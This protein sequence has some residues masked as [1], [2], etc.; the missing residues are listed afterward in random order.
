VVGRQEDLVL[1]DEHD[2]DAPFASQLARRLPIT[3][4]EAE[5]LARLAAGR[6]NDGIALDLGISRNTVIRH[7]ERIYAKLD[8]HTRVAAARAALAALRDED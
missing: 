7:V 3:P 2:D 6:T 4:R 8:V 5:V 1:L